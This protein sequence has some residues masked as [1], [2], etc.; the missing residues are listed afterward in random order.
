MTEEENK[1]LESLLMEITEGERHAQRRVDDGG[2][3][4]IH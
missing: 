4:G 3:V 2:S 1:E